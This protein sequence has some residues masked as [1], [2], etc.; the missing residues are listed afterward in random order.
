MLL[1]S[2]LNF[3]IAA[4]VINMPSSPVITDLDSSLTLSCIS[5]NSPPDTFTWR[6]DGGPVM[7][8]TS[9]IKE[10]HDAN[11]ADF[12]ADFSI[13]S[14]TADDGGTYTCNV[15]NPLGSNSAT[16]SVIVNSKLLI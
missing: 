3:Y 10:T 6:K 8:S 13:D 9:I 14:V 15:T 4:P 2:H 12:R 1:L 5:Q 7:E 16:I 11:R